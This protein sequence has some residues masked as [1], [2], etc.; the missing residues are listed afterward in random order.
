VNGREK[1]RRAELEVAALV[2]AWWDPLEPGCRFVR[3]PQSGGWHGPDVRAEFK[4]GGDLMTTAKRW[5]F[6]VEVKR[7][8]KWNLDNLMA[9]WPSP[10]WGWWE[11]CCTAAREDG[12]LP[13]LFLRKSREPWWA[14][15]DRGFEKLFGH[16]SLPAADAVE[17]LNLTRAP[18][19]YPAA[20]V[21]ES[22]PARVAR[23]SIARF[24]SRFGPSF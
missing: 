11:Q 16:P 10:A 20:K 23:F 2:Q 14:V 8:E 7:R 5:P 19:I 1:G 13:L 9:G 24:T 18:V 22:D 12:R 6:S 4:A 21:L 3:T 15:L 17:R